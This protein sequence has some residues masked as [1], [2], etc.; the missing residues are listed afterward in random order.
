MDTIPNSMC[1]HASTLLFA[2]GKAI[3]NVSG[4]TVHSLTFTGKFLSAYSSTSPI[5][6][7]TLVGSLSALERTIK[8]PPR[9]LFTIDFSFCITTLGLF[10]LCGTSTYLCLPTNWTRTCTLLYSSPNILI[11]PNDQPLPI[12]LIHKWIKQAIHFIP[13]LVGL[14][15]AAGIGIG[16]TGLTISIQNYWTLSKDLSDSLQEIVQ[17]LLTI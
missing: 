6:G 3:Y 12:P 10:F 2:T 4:P 8:P 9:L 5:L 17:G 14:G 11:T 1:N 15:L 7:A 16:T 13:L